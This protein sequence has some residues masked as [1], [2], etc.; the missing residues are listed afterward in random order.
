M[1]H[2]T[3]SHSSRPIPPH[4]CHDVAQRETG[5]VHLPEEHLPSLIAL[6]PSFCR[7]TSS[8]SH[9]PRSA[10]E[11]FGSPSVVRSPVLSCRG[12]QL[13][14]VAKQ[15]HAARS[16]RPFD[17]ILRPCR[18]VLD[19]ASRHPPPCC[20]HRLQPD[21]ARHSSIRP[22]CLCIGPAP[23]RCSCRCLASASS[24]HTTF[25]RILL[26]VSTLCV[27]RLDLR[28]NCASLG[29]THYSSCS[30]EFSTTPP[31]AC[32]KTTPSFISIVRKAMHWSASVTASCLLRCLSS[33][34][35][36]HCALFNLSIDNLVVPC[37]G[38]RS[39]AAAP[40]PP[41]AYQSSPQ[42]LHTPRA[43]LLPAL[44]SA[45]WPVPSALRSQSQQGKWI[46]CDMSI[47]ISE[48]GTFV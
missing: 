39:A 42:R 7:P 43:F 29:R 31:P 21:L 10:C 18:R 17:F 44:Q 9:R 28:H 41:S 19:A 20:G 36:I 6:E 1:A 33:S 12:L 46:C 45:P 5:T 15:E 24:M 30:S 4:A 25:A 11:P 2:H 13:A 14:T 47:Q 38:K 27:S 48:R 34:Y 40:Y 32:R 23:V 35:R 22:R 16:R 37:Q 3:A 26:S 8:S